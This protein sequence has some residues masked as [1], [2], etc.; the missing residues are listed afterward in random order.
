MANIRGLTAY[1]VDSTVRG[2]LV[3][4]LAVEE[5]A[6]AGLSGPRGDVVGD[7]GSLVGLE[8]GN[9][10]EVDGLRAEPE[11]LLGIEEVPGWWGQRSV[12]SKPSGATTYLGKLA[13]W[14]LCSRWPSSTGLTSSSFLASS[15]GATTAAAVSVAAGVSV[16]AAGVAST[17]RAA[18]VSVAAAA[19][20]SAGVVST[21]GSVA[22]VSWGTSVGFCVSAIVI[23]FGLICSKA[24]Y[25]KKIRKWVSGITE[26]TESKKKQVPVCDGGLSRR[27]LHW[28]LGYRRKSRGR[29]VLG[30]RGKREKEGEGAGRVTVDRATYFGTRQVTVCS[31]V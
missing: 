2:S 6:L 1:K 9:R 24:G 21:T 23:L 10:L 11:E 22:G 8:R 28:F 16:A 25:L 26:K 18:A 30:G 14:P 12:G 5:E 13:P 4:L 29:D 7:I 15:T 20:V 27:G 19:V 31:S 3:A 17:A